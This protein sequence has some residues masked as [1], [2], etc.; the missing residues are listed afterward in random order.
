V[1]PLTTQLAEIAG[2]RDPQD[3]LSAFGEVFAV[4]DDQDSGCLSYGVAAD[5][6]RW[7]VKLAPDAATAAMLRSAARFHAAVQ[8][9]VILAPLAFADLGERAGIG[10]PWAPGSVLYHP[11]KSHR[12]SRSD[13]ASP[14]SAFR[15]QPLE[16]VR[17][18]VD[19][20][21]DAH[22]AVATAGYLAVDFY[23]GC[24]LYDP[25]TAT[26]RLIDLDHYRPGPFTVG[27]KLLPGSTRYLSP[28][29][30]TAGAVVDERTT[31]YTLGRTALILMDEG[32]TEQAFRGTSAQRDVLAR[33]ASPD[34]A[35]RYG[36]V[37]QFIN[38]WRAI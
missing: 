8:H 15:A 3:R 20:I 14:M 19:D 22:L 6:A 30:R 29:E 37:A 7:F 31:V 10:Y 33:A 35:Q 25:P 23:D 34:P 12:P 38:A 2:S 1:P 17:R 24:M 11:T 21:F 32:D 27:P 13:P 16:I 36:T 18:V 28:E 9:P 4:F 5:T 26:I